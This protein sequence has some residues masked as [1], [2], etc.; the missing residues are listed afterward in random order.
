MENIF[1]H[2]DISGQR[3]FSFKK[4]KTFSELSDS[5]FLYPGY[6]RA[7]DIQLIRHF[8]LVSYLPD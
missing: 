2:T 8:L 5:F 1:H 4:M 3:K 6:V 7:A